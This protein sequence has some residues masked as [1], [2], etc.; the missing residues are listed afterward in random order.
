MHKPTKKKA[1]LKRP[2]AL[3]PDKT[4]SLFEDSA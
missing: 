2:S 4:A 1:S 3:F